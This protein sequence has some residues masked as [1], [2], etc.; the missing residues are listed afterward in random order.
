M[1]EAAVSTIHAWCNRMLTEHA[2]DSGNLFRR[3]HWETDQSDLLDEV[4]RDYRRMFIYS[5]SPALMD[6]VVGHWK[7]PDNCGPPCVT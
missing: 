2:F 1:D 4:V 6:E 7:T 5:L 3:R